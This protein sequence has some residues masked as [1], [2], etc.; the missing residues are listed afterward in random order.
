MQS[1]TPSPISHRFK[2]PDLLELALTHASTGEPEDNERLEFLGDAVLDLI[3][4]E[5]LY[6]QSPRLSEG[7]MT[8]YKSSVVARGPL[9]TAATDIGLDRIARLGAGL[10]RRIL[11]KSVMANLYEAVLG[12]IFLDAGLDASRAFV[13]SSLRLPL[14][15][16][17]AREA[18]A[19]PKQVLQHHSQRLWGNPPVYAE[20][21]SRGS[22]HARAFLVAAEAGGEQFPGAWG[23]TRKEA[24]RWAAH[25]AVLVLEERGDA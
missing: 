22:A 10:A 5:E 16:A 12:A 1:S 23:R 7:Q 25:E 3:V 18:R 8:E 13:K 9:A 6:A 20:L 4:A 14:R 17:K 19:N 11:P 24:E 2:N 21:E 15:R